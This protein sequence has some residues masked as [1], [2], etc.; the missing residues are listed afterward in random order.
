MSNLSSLYRLLTRYQT[1]LTNAQS[2]VGILERAV[3]DL[4]PASSKFELYYSIDSESADLKQIF[5]SKE[6]I[7]S[8][9]IFLSGTAIPAIRNKISQIKREI[10]KLESE[11]EEDK[12]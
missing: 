5:K 2:L 4:G 6:K 10:E 12:D 1:L 11:E 3:D 8:H 9:K 7:E